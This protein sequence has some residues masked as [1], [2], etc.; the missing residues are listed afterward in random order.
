MAFHQRFMKYYH[1]LNL[2]GR[3]HGYI[4]DEQHEALIDRINSVKTDMLFVGLGSPKQEKWIHQYRNFLKAKVCMGIGGS[5]DV[6]A[7]S[8]PRA[9][10]W[11][12][13]RGLEWLYCLIREPKRLRRQLV[14]P[15]YALKILKERFRLK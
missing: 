15:K 4:P 2:A 11:L 5:L 13:R 9:P 10:D 1:P 7:D 12:Q 6:M 14:L 3:E 8:V